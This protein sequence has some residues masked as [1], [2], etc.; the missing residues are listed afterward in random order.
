[1]LLGVMIFGPVLLVIAHLNMSKELSPD[2]KNRWRRLLFL[3]PPVVAAYYL[4][5]SQR[6]QP[7]PPSNE[8]GA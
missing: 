2:D 8:G 7:S 3:L 4:T 5:T 6:S 1:V